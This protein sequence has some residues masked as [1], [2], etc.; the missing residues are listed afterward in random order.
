MYCVAFIQ[1][2]HHLPLPIGFQNRVGLDQ[3]SSINN[4]KVEMFLFVFNFE[5]S[6]PYFYNNRGPH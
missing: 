6:W 3:F 1:N 5:I 2:N 4:T